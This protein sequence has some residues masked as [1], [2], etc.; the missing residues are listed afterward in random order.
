[1]SRDISA[2]ISGVVDMRFL[3]FMPLVRTDGATIARLAITNRLWSYTGA[4]TDHIPGHILVY[5]A[6]NPAA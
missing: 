4:A 1:M 5:P 3:N 6:R 2:A